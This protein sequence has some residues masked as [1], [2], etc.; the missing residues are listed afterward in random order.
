[1]LDDRLDPLEY[2]PMFKTGTGTK[3]H[4]PDWETSLN[5]R[6]TVYCFGCEDLMIAD[7]EYGWEC[8]SC[9]GSLMFEDDEH[10]HWRTAG[11]YDNQ[12]DEWKGEEGGCDIASL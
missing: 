6:A 4:H 2:V 3:I 9:G 5:W 1:M 7:D 11:W 12:I 10:W 8:V